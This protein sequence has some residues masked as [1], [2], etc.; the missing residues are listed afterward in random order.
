MITK[1]KCKKCKY[2]PKQAPMSKGT[3]KCKESGYFV[4][5]KK[6]GCDTYYEPK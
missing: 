3:V 1:Q 2:E 5:V 4:N 6:D